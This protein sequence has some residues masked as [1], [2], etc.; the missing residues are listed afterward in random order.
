MLKK[1]AENIK[2]FF[3]A[4]RLNEIQPAIHDRGIVMTTAQNKHNNNMENIALADLQLQKDALQKN[5]ILM[6]RTM[7]VALFAAIISLI[8]GVYA[9][10][11]KPH[12]KVEVYEQ[13]TLQKTN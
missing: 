3:K 10:V 2:S 4:P 13:K 5:L 6:H 7:L 12:V 1:L 9:V 8:L 11:S